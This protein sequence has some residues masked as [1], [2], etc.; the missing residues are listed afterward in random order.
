[1]EHLELWKRQKQRAACDLGTELGPV[2]QRFSVASEQFRK[3]WR[4]AVS[5]QMRQSR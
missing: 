2:P 3:Y 4:I 5:V 1:M